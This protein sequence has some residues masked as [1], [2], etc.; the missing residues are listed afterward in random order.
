MGTAAAWK[1]P[2]VMLHTPTSGGPDRRR[3]PSVWRRSMAGFDPA[4]RLC[5]RQ[6]PHRLQQ[7]VEEVVAGCWSRV[8]IPEA[9]AERQQAGGLEAQIDRTHPDQAVDRQRRG[10]EQ[11]QPEGNLERDQRRPRLHQSPRSPEMASISNRRADV[12]SRQRQCRHHGEEEA[13]RDRDDG[14]ERERAGVETVGKHPIVGGCVEAEPAECEPANQQGDGPAK[15]PSTIAST[16]NCLMIRP[17]AGAES[18]SDADFTRAD[19]RAGNQ[20]RGQVGAGDQQ[21]TG[22]SHDEQPEKRP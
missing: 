12:L 14:G 1:Y 2:G 3:P 21:D 18:R 19:R 15:P 11:D 9:D 10:R 6:A 5:V 7:L 20:Q 16:N 8:P 22:G 13:G 17:A 4:S